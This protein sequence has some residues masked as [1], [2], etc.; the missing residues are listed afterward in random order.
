MIDLSGRT[1]LVGGASRGIGRACAEAFANCGATVVL[2][3]RDPTRLQQVCDG[4]RRE[5]RQAHR[6]FPADTSDSDGL[7]HKIESLL[8]D[9]GPIE[10][11]VNNT[12]GPPPGTILE[13]EPEAFLTAM[14]M[15]ICA[16]HVLV[17]ALTPGMKQRGYGRIIN[18]VSTSV[19]Q[20]IPNLGVSNTVRGATAS[21]AKTLANE[22]GPFGIT[23]NNILPGFTDTDR[24]RALIHTNAQEAGLSDEELTRRMT[25]EIPLRRFADP[26][27]TAAVAAFLASPAASY[28]TG[29][30]V[31][32]DGGRI[33]AI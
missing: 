5:Q 10:I 20:P 9:I 31:P 3:S 33:S 14:R 23:V 25:A 21:W 24:L 19:R 13:A 7:R 29:T 28:V 22:L 4:L 18:I 26:R 1:A 32:V 6:I 8:A 2:M 17:R 16:A 27:E 15:H 11:L 12:G 30:S